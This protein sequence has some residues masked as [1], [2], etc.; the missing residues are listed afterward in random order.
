MRPIGRKDKGDEGS[1][2]FEPSISEVRNKCWLDSLEML[3]ELREGED[4]IVL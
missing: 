4:G 1:L 2:D 3:E